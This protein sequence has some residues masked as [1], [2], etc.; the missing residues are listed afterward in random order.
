[1]IFDFNDKTAIVTGA[2]SGIGEAIAVR[3]AASGALVIVSDI[4][5]AA[6]SRTALALA[7][8]RV[9]VGGLDS[10][11]ARVQRGRRVSKARPCRTI[12]LKEKC[13]SEVCSPRDRHS[14]WCLV[15]R[16]L[17]T[18]SGMDRDRPQPLFRFALK[19]LVHRLA[20]NKEY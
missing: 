7:A 19:E 6:A 2:A 3:L 12:V 10:A 16:D 17:S 5:E 13:A 8:R 9:F 4:D 14:K 11:E 1:M 20:V 15:P 18:E